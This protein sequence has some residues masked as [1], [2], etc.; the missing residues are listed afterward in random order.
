MSM[1]AAQLGDTVISWMFEDFSDVIDQRQFSCLKG[2]SYNNVL[3]VRL[4]PQLAEKL[5]KLWML[6]EGLLT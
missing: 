2:S 6:S 4:V 5:R 3:S 1:C